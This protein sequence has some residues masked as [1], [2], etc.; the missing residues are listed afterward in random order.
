M[1]PEAQYGIKATLTSPKVYTQETLS[2]S[3][4]HFESTMKRKRLQDQFEK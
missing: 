3:N 4:N 1:L 2:N